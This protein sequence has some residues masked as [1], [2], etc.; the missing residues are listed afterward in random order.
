[1]VPD[2]TSSTAI[3][4]PRPRTSPI[5]SST[6]CSVVNRSVTRR[7]IWRARSISPSLS[8]VAM[9][10][11][12]AAQ[13]T[14]LP[15]NVPPRPPTCGAFM[16]SARPVTADSGNPSAMP[17]AVQIRSGSRP[18]GPSCSQANIAPVRAKPVCTSSAMNTTWFLRHQSRRAGR[19]PSAGTMKPPSPWI[20]SMTRAA[21]LFAPT[22]L[23]MTPMAR[24]AASSPLVASCL[25]RRPS[26]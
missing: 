21:R 14:G 11:S 16:I 1:M 18:S 4:A 6:A 10:A 3:M 8:M 12:A 13:A 19:N 20:G 9:V 7:S 24:A 26:R 22:C 15:P 25:S 5:R 2:L 17:L 23:S